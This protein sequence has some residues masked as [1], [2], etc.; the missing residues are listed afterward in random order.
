MTCVAD[1][2]AMAEAHRA[3]LNAYLQKN[4]RQPLGTSA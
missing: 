4:R 1:V 3:D 2:D